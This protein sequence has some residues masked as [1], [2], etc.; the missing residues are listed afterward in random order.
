MFPAARVTDMH[1]CPMVTGVVP[2]VGGPILP[3]GV[4]TILIAGLPAAVA[5]GMC[6]CVGPPDLIA[7]GSAGCLMAGKPAARM[8]DRCAHGGL[9][10]TGC[11]TV[12]I[13]D[14]GSGSKSQNKGG[15]RSQAGTMRA[16]H[17]LASPFTKRSCDKGGKLASSLPP[18]EPAEPVTYIEIVLKDTDGKPCAGEP[19]EILVPGG[20][21]RTGSLDQN[22][23]A[24]EVGLDPGTCE[25]SFPRLD[26][27]TWDHA[28]GA[29]MPGENR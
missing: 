16:A 22:G 4:P 20:D 26:G 25:V 18:T 3:P 28:G 6:V 17:R 27:R 29:A 2:H 24:I 10:V 7:K 9:I 11:P 15:G 23:Y 19:Y 1:A 8:T 12:L 5:T 14:S 21:L 13:G